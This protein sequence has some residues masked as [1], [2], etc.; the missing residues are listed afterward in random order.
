METNFMPVSFAGEKTSWHG[1]DRYDFSMS[2]D[3]KLQPLKAAPEEANG[4]KHRNHGRRCIVVLPKTNALG[5]PWSWRGCY[6]DHQPQTEVELLKRGFCVAYIEASQDLRPDKSWDAWYAF[7]TEKHGLSPKPAFIGMSRGGEFS[8]TWAVRN[9]SKVS[10]IYADNPGGNWEVM[11]GLS[12]LATNDVPLLHVCGSIDPILGLFTLP[13]ESTYQQFGGRI[14]VMIKEGRGHHPHSLRDPA[15]LADFIQNSVRERKGMPA[16]F[17]GVK[18]S[19]TSFYPTSKVYRSF[20]GEQTYVTVRG[21]LFTNCY[22]RYYI[23]LKGVDAF[24]TVIAPNQPAPGNPWMFRVDLVDRNDPVALALLA[25]GFYIVTGA[26]PYNFDGPVPAQWD[27][28]YKHFVDHGFSKK[29]AMAGAGGAAGEAYGWAI[30]NPDKVSCLYAENPIL[31]SNLAKTQPLDSLA[32][33]AQAKIP[34]LHVCGSEDPGLETNTRAEEKQYRALGGQMDVI[35]EKG[36]GHYPL[37]PSDP[38]TVVDFITAA[39]SR[40]QT[41]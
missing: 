29:P 25:K 12:G 41:Y 17:A 15:F 26:V 31:H 18:F 10:C 4:Y 32:S 14:S 30:A 33:L 3:L 24:T 6:W 2:E 8:Y 34:I 39:T 35:I 37:S 22:D 13:I 27:V 19:K 40:A 36:R 23:T 5:N 11:N 38:D 28:I 21:P 7:L 1:F 9:P 16:D 20:V